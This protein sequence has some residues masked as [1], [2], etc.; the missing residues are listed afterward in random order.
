MN[1]KIKIL[2]ITNNIRISNGVSS[3]MFNY[4]RAMDKQNIQI[5]F[6]LIDRQEGSYEEE[7]LEMKTKIH[8]LNN[9]FS[10]RN[11]KKIQ[12][13]VNKFFEEHQYD[14]VELHAPTFAFIFLKMAK[15]NNIPIRIIHSHS[16]VHSNNKLKNI[17]S[18]LL[19]INFKRYA[20]KFFACSEKSGKYWYG[21]KICKS[22]SYEIIPNGVDTEKYQFNKEIRK[23]IREQYGI[24]ND[25][26]IGFVGRIAKEKNLPFLVKVLEKLLLENKKYKFLVIGDGP[27]LE[28]IQAMCNR[29]K[30]NVIFFGRRADVNQLL[31]CI[32]LL[33]LP[34]KRE[35]LPMVAVE[36][37]L[38]GVTCYLSNTITNEVDIGNTTFLKL[39]NKEWINAIK[40]FKNENKEIDRRKFDINICAKNLEEIYN[41]YYNQTMK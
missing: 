9:K 27:D 17:L 21:N 20:N 11:I 37:Q 19:N 3:V 14:I 36:A 5:E 22:N 13:E 16:T 10:I 39:K 15:K 26:V 23:K 1:K 29:I 30:Q 7:L 4:V 35:G 33:V 18:I 38:A 12:N 41:R 2:Y 28:N 31:N 25:I 32:D 8:Y 24:Q 40:N 6:L 34:S